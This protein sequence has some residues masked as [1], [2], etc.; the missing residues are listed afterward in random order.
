[1]KI[2]QEMVG[3]DIIWYHVLWQ[4]PSQHWEGTAESP[5]LTGLKLGYQKNTYCDL[6][7]KFLN[8]VLIFSR[9]NCHFLTKTQFS[10]KPISL[11]MM[12][13]WHLRPSLLQLKVPTVSLLQDSLAAVRGISQTQPAP[14]K[15]R[16][17]KF[18]GTEAPKA[19]SSNEKSS[20]NPKASKAW[21]LRGVLCSECIR[22]LEVTSQPSRNCTQWGPGSRRLRLSHSPSLRP[23]RIYIYIYIYISIL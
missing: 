17:A 19:F 22:T 9:L 21:F 3:N 8:H 5:Q 15:H 10:D 20:A 14:G 2:T 6:S 16:A 11:G 18:H 13:T 23:H 7:A 1:M 4:M 12:R